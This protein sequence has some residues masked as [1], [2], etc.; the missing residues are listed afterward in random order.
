MKDQLT[1]GQIAELIHLCKMTRNYRKISV[2]GFMLINNLANRIGTKVGLEYRKEHSDESIFKYL[3]RINTCS[4]QKL[5]INIINRALLQELNRLEHFFH[6]KKGNLTLNQIERLFEIYYDL[7]KID[8]P[9]LI[10]NEKPANSEGK[11]PLTTLFSGTSKITQKKKVNSNM[12]LDFLLQKEEQEISNQLEKEFDSDLLKKKVEIGKL[13]NRFTTPSK[14][15]EQTPALP[16]LIRNFILGIMIIC[17]IMGLILLVEVV[18][19]SFLSGVFG[20]LTFGLLG[21]AGISYLIYKK[22][23][24]TNK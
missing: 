22:S 24:D 3:K 19:N 21:L 5:S 4:N 15:K 18:M 2:A 6:E 13:R 14:P 12:L 16:I 11:I 17:L 8:L 20:L 10:T 23:G 7:R 1:D 9:A